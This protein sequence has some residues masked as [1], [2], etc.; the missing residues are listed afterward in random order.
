MPVAVLL[1]FGLA[2]PG[3]ANA[4]Q[5]DSFS[6][7]AF[8][9]TDGPHPGVLFTAT[10]QDFR[11]QMN[12]HDFEGANGDTVRLGCFSPDAFGNS[13]PIPCR[14]G[15]TVSAFARQGGG[16]TGF[17]SSMVLGGQI[18]PGCDGNHRDPD[19]DR[20]ST[21]CVT[22]HVLGG[23]GWGSA[24]LPPFA[25]PPPGHPV[26]APPDIL[27]LA[28]VAT[29]FGVSDV[30]ATIWSS[31]HGA[32]TPVDS[33][34]FN[35]PFDLNPIGGGIGQFDLEWDPDTETWLPLFAEGRID[36]TV[37]PEPATLLL[38]ATTGAGLGLIRRSRRRGWEHAA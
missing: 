8:I 7:S 6:L 17:G 20:G 32:P 33:I 26:P 3:T 23:L 10:A 36:V 29:T 19:P 22:G 13:I 35:G 21:L 27:N 31:E 1:F 11:F 28:T 38:L 2:V 14:P 18:I 12:F 16:I 9:G 24:V 30:G 25:G 4:L 37:T 5:F 34:V 15:G